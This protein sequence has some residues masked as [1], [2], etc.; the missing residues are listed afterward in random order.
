VDKEGLAARV[1]EAGVAA[2]LRLGG[3]DMR[4]ILNILQVRAAVAGRASLG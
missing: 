4:R 2:V 1:E 3:G